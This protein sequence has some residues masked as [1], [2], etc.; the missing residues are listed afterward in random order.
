V[1]EPT[2]IQ[3]TPSGYLVDFGD[4][5]PRMVPESV[6]VSMGLV[7]ATQGLYDDRA[8]GPQ[9]PDPYAPVA[10]PVEQAA[11]MTTPQ[12]QPAASPVTPMQTPA[13]PAVPPPAPLGSRSSSLSVG[14]STTD[15]VRRTDVRQPPPS[16]DLAKQHGKLDEQYGVL[17]RS[18]EAQEVALKDRA[19]AQQRADEVKY[20]RYDAEGNLVEEGGAQLQ[21]ELMDRQLEARAAFDAVTQEYIQRRTGEI[22]ERIARVPQEDPG[23]IWQDN[24]AFQNA[25]GLLSAFLGGMLAVSTGSGRNMGLEAIERAIDRNIQAQRTNIENEWKRVAHD[26][27]TL[28]QYQQ[29][30]GNERQWMLEEQAVRLETLALETEAKAATFGSQARYAEHMGLAAELRAK[31]AEKVAELIK[32]ETEMAIAENQSAQRQWFELEKLSLEKRK[33]DA[34]VKYANAQTAKLA[35]EG[36]GGDPLVYVHQLPSPDG[37]TPGKQLVLD[38]KFAKD[39]DKAQIDSIRKDTVAHAA[40]VDIVHKYRQ[41]VAEIGS[42]FAGKGTHTRWGKPEVAAVKDAQ[43]RAAAAIARSLS[44][45]QYAD[46][47]RIAVEKFLGDPKG[48]TGVDPLKSQNAYLADELSAMERDLGGRGV[49]E[50]EAITA[51]KDGDVPAI[52]GPTVSGPPVRAEG[53]VLGQALAPFS[54]KDNFYAGDV[55]TPPDAQPLLEE[56]RDLGRVVLTGSDP[57]S[58]LQA[59]RRINGLLESPL[60]LTPAITQSL[61]TDVEAGQVGD[62]ATVRYPGDG[63]AQAGTQVRSPVEGAQLMRVAAVRAAAAADAQGNPQLA[64]EIMRAADSIQGRLVSGWAMDRAPEVHPQADVGIGSVTRPAFR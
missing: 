64:G 48:W 47:F 34:E 46:A 42:Q 8:S 1:A 27:D 14:G 3:G 38:P 36:K 24:S 9:G 35:A 54:A 53:A 6:A 50:L 60:A 61:F 5:Q 63:A 16:L 55:V 29:W 44:G 23:K 37:K 62:K 49:V 56:A 4:G 22:N 20:G 7:G 12:P 13:P 57:S 33:T 15:F 40:V 11:A 31:Q 59:L 2:A 19:A 43:S 41:R 21:A 51:G 58:T 32:Q 30:K 39:M 52:A 28:A 45:S 17:D 18:I 10:A 25:A 26:K